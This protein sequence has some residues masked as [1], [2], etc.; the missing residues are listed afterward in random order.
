MH[1]PDEVVRTRSADATTAVTQG[2][3]GCRS[4]PGGGDRCGGLWILG[5]EQQLARRPGRLDERGDDT[6][7][8][9]SHDAPHDG[10]AQRRRLLLTAVASSWS[11][12]WARRRWSA[13]AAALVLT[14]VAGWVA[15]AGGTDLAGAGLLWETIRSAPGQMVGPVLVAVVGAMFVAERFWPSERRPART[16]AHLVDAAYM[17]LYAA[18]APLV[19]LFNTGFALAVG[20]HAP[21]L[22]LGR[23]PLLPQVVVVA[24]ILVGIDAMNWLAH[25]ANHRSATLWRFHAL[26][27]SQEQM[28][29]L[30]TFRT[31]PLTHVAYL[32]ALIPALVLEA[33]GSVPA[34]ALVGYGCL[35]AVSHANLRWTYGRLGRVVV[36][37]AYHRIHHASTP[38][39]GTGAVNFGFVLAV[40][41]RVAGTAVDPV[42]SRI[43]VTGLAGRP[44]PVEQQRPGRVVALVTAQLLQPFR[45]RSGLEVE[46]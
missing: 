36:S 18:T 27:H 1:H 15:V 28:S 43:V 24:L 4:Q 22:I 11:P 3:G 45:L 32:P 16:A 2:S 13:W 41:D 39:Q 35:V 20:H 38:V 14:A 29:V 25:G 26:H 21:F 8:D 40:W 17:G 33:S 34:G 37:P 31:H 46:R 23:L 5:Q 7:H 12:A 42:P 6:V 19:I 44:V 30:T 9:G 10:S